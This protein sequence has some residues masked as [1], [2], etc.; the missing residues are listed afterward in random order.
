MH[1]KRVVT[2]GDV[3]PDALHQRGFGNQF[4]GCFDENLYDV[5][6]AGSNGSRRSTHAQLVVQEI[7]LQLPGS[8][9][10]RPAVGHLRP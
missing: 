10:A 4:S 9:N 7:N 8:I 3:R 5:E 2:D 1:L 6:S